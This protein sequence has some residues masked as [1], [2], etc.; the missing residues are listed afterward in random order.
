[1]F[2]LK[3]TMQPLR[4]PYTVR[5]PLQDVCRPLKLIKHELSGLLHRPRFETNHSV[6]AVL[7][8]FVLENTSCYEGI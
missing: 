5:R 1:M 7:V 2:L 6:S 8:H 4:R 3:V